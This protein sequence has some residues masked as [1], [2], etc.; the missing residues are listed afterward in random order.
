MKRRTTSTAGSPSC[1]RPT[2]ATPSASASAIAA[3][4]CIVRRC[5]APAAPAAGCG[6]TASAGRAIGAD[7][8]VKLAEHLTVRGIQDEAKAIDAEFAGG[9]GKLPTKRRRR[10]RQQADQ[11]SRRKSAKSKKA[12]A[13]TS[14]PSTACGR[15]R[16]DHPAGKAAQTAAA[17]RKR[18]GACSECTSLASCAAG[19][20]SPKP[21][22]RWCRSRGTPRPISRSTRRS[23]TPTCS[24][25]TSP[26]A[27]WCSA[28]NGTTKAS[29]CRAVTRWR[30]PRR[31]HQIQAARPAT[32]ASPS[33]R[34]SLRA[35]TRLPAM[36]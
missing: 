2:S 24:P 4:F 32:T 30:G 33:C 20:G 27:R 21:T 31:L 11:G 19:A 7:E 23:S 5:R 13:G 16:E 14:R 12:T 35:W 25:S 1:R 6:G 28:A 22:P 17:A 15:D 3:S 26:T 8:K 10:S 29:S 18:H 36:S 34:R 9:F